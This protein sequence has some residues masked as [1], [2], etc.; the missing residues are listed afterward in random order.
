M[1]VRERAR[2]PA[3]P[4]PAPAPSSPAPSSPASAPP[5]PTP[6]PAPTQS[7]PPPSPAPAPQGDAAAQ[8]LALINQARAQA[9]LPALLAQ[10]R[11]GHQLRPA[12]RGDG[13]GLRAVPPVPGRA[14]AR[15]SGRPARACTGP[16]PGRTSARAARG[17]HHVGDRPDGDPD[18]PVHARRAAAR[19]RP[20][21]EHPEPDVPVIGITVTRDSHGTVWMTQ[22]F[23]S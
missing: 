14:I 4:S 23:S 9:G 5:T 2:D 13:R 8:V 6:T 19:R 22:D 10:Q 21:G 20:P 7:Y 16:R 12:Q 1:R 15:H 18:H 17:Q 3:S 11:P